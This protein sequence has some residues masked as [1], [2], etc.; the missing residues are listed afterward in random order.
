LDHRDGQRVLGQTFSDLRL[1]PVAIVSLRSG[2]AE[3]A[4]LPDG[5][6]F[7]YAASPPP[8]R[9]PTRKE[10]EKLA[11]RLDQEPNYEF[12]DLL[13]LT[14]VHQING[15]ERYRSGDLIRVHRSDGDWSL[16]VVTAP[17]SKGRL[18]VLVRSKPEGA[19]SVKEL[20]ED[21]VLKA[22]L[23]KIGDFVQI[24]STPFWV[25]GLDLDGELLVVTKS[26]QRIDPSELAR[27]LRKIVEERDTEVTVQM[28]SED[29]ERLL[30][31]DIAP[32][33]VSRP[34]PTRPLSVARPVSPGPYV[35]IESILSA[36]SG[37]GLWAG[38]KETDT[39]YDLKS[40]LAGAALHTSRGHNYKSWNEDGGALFADGNGR[41]YLGVFDQA[42]GEGSDE[43]ARGAASAIAAE[44]LFDEMQAI[45]EA[46]GNHEEAEAA[47][48]RAAQRAH[49]AILERSKGEVTTFIGG[50]IDA[51]QAT[52]VNIGDSGAMHFDKKGR[53]LRSTEAQGVGRLL[54]EGLGMVR[55]RGFAHVT[56]KWPVTRGDLLIFGSD[57]LFDSRLE[58][59]E[60]G[61]MAARAKTAADAT[62]KLRDVVSERMKAKKA[63]P[64]NLTVLVVRVGE[65]EK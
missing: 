53:H 26:H 14:N 20:S 48:I 65:T 8:M 47:L 55:K 4:S 33:S 62:R 19:L 38:N 1:A 36:S 56:Y 61:K 30:G 12:L 28:S 11:E 57:G 64:D 5:F 58:P 6:S 40:P 39:V 23:L 9:S 13:R 34:M 52:I 3:R 15:I 42:G 60:I 29:R 18:R 27:R 41:L 49:D 63:K 16:G 31:T 35:P 45:A 44:M 21:S 46:N 59:E 22:N 2:R 54:L 7:D 51:H 37:Y 25:A 50:M 17:A 10:L 43:Q 24:D 32:I